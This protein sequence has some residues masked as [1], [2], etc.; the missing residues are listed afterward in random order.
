MRIRAGTAP[1][2]YSCK[3]VATGAATCSCVINRSLLSDLK[4]RAGTVP[5]SYRCKKVTGLLIARWLQVVLRVMQA[6]LSSPSAVLRQA[7][8]QLLCSV[9]GW[10]QLP[11]AAVAPAAAQVPDD[12]T[13][14]TPAQ[15]NTAEAAGAELCCPG[16]R[17]STLLASL[18]NCEPTWALACTCKHTTEQSASC[19][20][21]LYSAGWC[22]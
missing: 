2:S 13:A 4:I 8:L 7:T 16:S 22:D 10:A 3:K 9:S 14:A 5:A 11:A 17:V 21:A 20:S 6:N 1:A 12:H 19:D 15:A 18:S